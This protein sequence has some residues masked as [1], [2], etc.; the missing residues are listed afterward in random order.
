MTIGRALA[1]LVSSCLAFWLALTPLAAAE[2]DQIYAKSY[3][4]VV[5][6]DKY[7]YYPAGD[8]AHARRDA[9][10]MAKFLRARGF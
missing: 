2:V 9:E 10:G 1:C 5:G 4:L 6:I 7:P 8:L 3:A